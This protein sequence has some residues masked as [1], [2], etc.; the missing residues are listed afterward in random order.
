MAYPIFHASYQD[1][2]EGDLDVMNEDLGVKVQMKH[3]FLDEKNSSNY[4]AYYFPAMTKDEVVL[5]KEW[6][7]DPQQ[8]AKLCF[9]SAFKD[10]NAAVDAP[11]RQSIDGMFV[12]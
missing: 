6:D 10:P 11:D 9:H 3:F 8:L 7:S 12:A 4:R 2:I 5:F 1:M